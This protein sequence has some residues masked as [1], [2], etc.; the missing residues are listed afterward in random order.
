MSINQNIKIW[1]YKI[2]KMIT[3]FKLSQKKN[4]LT[5]RYLW[6]EIRLICEFYDKVLLEKWHIQ[7]IY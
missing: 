3:R 2:I 7:W 5:N 4:L 1:I 6:D